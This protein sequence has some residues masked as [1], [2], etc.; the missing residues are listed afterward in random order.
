MKKPNLKLLTVL[1]AVA[2]IAG[3]TIF[4][5]CNK[6]EKDNNSVKKLTQETEFVAKNYGD[7]CVQVNIFRDENNNAQFVIKDLD[8]VS[9]V[10]TGIRISKMLN[11]ESRKTK[12]AEEFVIDIP[13]DAIYWLVPLDGNMPVKFE[14]INNI[15]NAEVGGFVKVKCECSLKRPNCLGES[16]C[17][18]PQYY[19]DKDGNLIV[20][21]V[22]DIALAGNCCLTCKAVIEADVTVS[23]TTLIIVGSAYLIQSDTITING[24]TYE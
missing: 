5:A 18:P 6:D 12:N 17:R 22:P 8:H 3:V 20:N 1:F 11:I 7:A 19:K 2:L 9:E 23:N 14:P 24:I 10:L 15:E 21:C 16:V 4:Y 13:N